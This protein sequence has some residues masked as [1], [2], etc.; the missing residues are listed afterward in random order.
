MRF[1]Q[2]TTVEVNAQSLADVQAGIAAKLGMGGNVT[3]CH[4][5][6]LLAD[7]A[8]VRA[9]AELG[10]V[11]AV[12]VWP[13]RCFY[14]DGITP[15]PLRARSATKPVLEKSSEQGRKPDEWDLLGLRVPEP[16]P[17]PEPEQ[18]PLPLGDTDSEPPELEPEPEL[19]PPKRDRRPSILQGLIVPAQTTDEPTSYASSLLALA[20]EDEEEEH[21]DEEE[22]EHELTQPET[23]RRLQE[24]P[25]PEPESK[26]ADH[27]HQQQQGGRVRRPS[28][29]QSLL[30]SGHASDEP[31]SVAPSLQLLALA[32]EDEEEDEE[33]DDDDEARENRAD[34]LILEGH[35][36]TVSVQTAKE[37][38]TPR[39]DGD[40][41]QQQQQQ[42]QPELDQELDALLS[43]DVDA[44]ADADIDTDAEQPVRVSTAE[45]EELRALVEVE[46]A[47]QEQLQPQ[48][49]PQIGRARRPSIHQS[50]LGSGGMDDEPVSVAPSLEALADEDD[51]E[52]DE[53]EDDDDDEEEEEVEGVGADA[54]VLEGHGGTVRL[55]ETQE[56]ED[57]PFAILAAL[58][59]D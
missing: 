25:Q 18:Q 27:H 57:D 32:D 1:S 22:E 26:L 56:G 33:E 19:K 4:V 28:I 38:A 5:V 42:Q 16:E 8:P 3:I 55:D 20:D 58:L 40:S 7:A 2:V 14:T 12:S 31:V 45:E 6:G 15:L 10:S 29:V 11:Q 44:D 50:L 34:A 41:Q 43:V 13:S 53:E 51:E 17:E 24:Q 54:L 52:E 59:P 23:P 47:G 35:G 36:G 9:L 21:E 49:Q 30:G 48:E 46:T 37:P 39:L